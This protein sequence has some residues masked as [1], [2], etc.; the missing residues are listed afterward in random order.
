LTAAGAGG[1]DL[2]SP[3]APLGL[4]LR[5]AGL[6]V[7][8]IAPLGILCAHLV[9][10]WRGRRRTAVDLLLLSPLVLPP[11]VVGFLLLHHLLRLKP[12]DVS[13]LDLDPEDT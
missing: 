8:C 12:E 10:S 6:A 5:S 4:S 3:W 11:T 2:I 1:G 7:A 9:R 13:L